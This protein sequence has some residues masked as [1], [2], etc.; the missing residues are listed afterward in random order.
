MSLAPR[1]GKSLPVIPV[2]EDRF[3]PG[4]HDPA[5]DRQRW[6]KAGTALVMVGGALVVPLAP[7][8]AQ[9]A[10]VPATRVS[11]R[12][13]GTEGGRL[14]RV[15]KVLQEPQVRRTLEQFPKEFQAQVRQL[16]DAQ[17]QVLFGG[18]SG[19]TKIG[20]LTVNHREAFI[21]GSFMGK[22]VWKNVHQSVSDAEAKYKMIRPDE[23][24]AL[25]RVVDQAAR[26]TPQQRTM[27]ADLL[28]L[29]Q[30]KRHG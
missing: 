22:S 21:K 29:A 2:L 8:S 14:T 6:M 28:V 16:S 25:H 27:L 5:D 10:Q 24:R 12:E 4:W 20:P 3:T 26:F 23:A 1:P 9:A 17:L 18:V 7:L 13:G 30:G 11:P 19:T 15:G